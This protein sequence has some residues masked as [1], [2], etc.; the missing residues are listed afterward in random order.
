MLSQDLRLFCLLF[1]TLLREVRLLAEGQLPDTDSLLYTHQ[2]VTSRLTPL[3]ITIIKCLKK[4]N[5]QSRAVDPDP[6]GSIC[7]SGSR[8]ENLSNKNRKNA[9]KLL[10]TSSLFNVFKVPVNL[11]K[12]HC[13]LLVSN[14]LFFYN[15]RK[16]FMSFLYKFC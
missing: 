12:V 14:L 3:T 1:S 5:I 4:T 15:Y 16:L 8:R 13:F 10:I 9:R 6:H 7:G 11:H 2:A